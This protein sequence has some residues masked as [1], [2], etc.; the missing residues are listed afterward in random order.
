M[1]TR[2][3]APMSGEQC[4]PECGSCFSAQS[5]AEAWRALLQWVL[6]GES[7][8]DTDARTMYAQDLID[9]NAFDDWYDGVAGRPDGYNRPPDAILRVLRPYLLDKLN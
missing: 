7:R 1:R 9:G 4:K 3:G 2:M 5:Q 8:A 6:S